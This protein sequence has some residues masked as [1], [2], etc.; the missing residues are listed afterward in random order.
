VVRE[1]HSGNA[2]RPFAAQ[3]Q[4]PCATTSTWNREVIV[5]SGAGEVQARLPDEHGAADF[6]DALHLACCSAEQ[7]LP[8]LTFDEKAARLAGARG[9]AGMA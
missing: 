1:Y 8:F 4:A 2:V 9:V 7:A 6:A 3:R 5:F